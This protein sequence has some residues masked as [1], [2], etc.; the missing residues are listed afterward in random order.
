MQG[1]RILKLEKLPAGVTRRSLVSAIA[2]CN[3]HAEV[4]ASLLEGPDGP[5]GLVDEL[6]RKRIAGGGF[7]EREDKKGNPKKVDLLET[8]ERL[9]VEGGES[10]IGLNFRLALQGPDS[11]RPD[12][13]L[14]WLLELDQRDLARCS[15]LKTDAELPRVAVPAS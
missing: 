4:P 7:I 8:L 5:V 2:A 9:V 15:I 6:R 3:W 10:K 11:E 12:R 13:F 14:A 1:F